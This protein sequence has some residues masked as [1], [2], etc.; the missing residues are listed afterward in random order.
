MKYVKCD[1]VYVSLKRALW[2]FTQKSLCKSIH[3][4]LLDTH[5]KRGTKI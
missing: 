3:V 4:Q 1:V 2:V 5:L